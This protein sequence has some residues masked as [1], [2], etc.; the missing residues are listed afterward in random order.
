V[1]DF[2]NHPQPQQIWSLS[3]VATLSAGSNHTCALQ[4]AGRVWCWGANNAGQIGT[5]DVTFQPGQVQSPS[6]YYSP[7]SASTSQNTTYFITGAGQMWGFGNGGSGQLC[8]AVSQVSRSSPIQIGAASDWSRVYA[9]NSCAFA[10]KTNGTLWSW[11]SNSSG[12]LGVGDTINRSSPTQIGALTTWSKVWANSATVFALKTDG[13]LWGWGS[14]SNNLLCIAGTANPNRSSPVQIGSAADWTFIPDVP[15]ATSTFFVGI[16]AGGGVYA[17]GSLAGISSYA[18]YSSNLP[19]T[20]PIQFVASTGWSKVQPM[21]GVQR[22]WL[23][24]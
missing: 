18:P 7:I 24:K 21:D 6:N 16:R 5:G 9:G 1:A 19:G 15:V 20:E 13:T 2:Q 22:L 4:Q 8:Q 3:Q 12:Q 10:I 17:S 23:L 14:D 11:G